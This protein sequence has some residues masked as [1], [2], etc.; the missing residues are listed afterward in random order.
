MREDNEGS[1]FAHRGKEEGGGESWGTYEEKLSEVTETYLNRNYACM[2]A[3]I[4]GY[5]SLTIARPVKWLT[6][7]RGSVN[8][9][10][11][12]QVATIV[13]ISYD[14]PGL[15]DTGITSRRQYYLALNKI[16]KTWSILTPSTSKVSK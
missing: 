8:A 10:E 11:L 13:A 16:D 2:R 3:I 9:S 14:Y 15:L 5:I 7:L 6:E 4:I 12:P 1:K